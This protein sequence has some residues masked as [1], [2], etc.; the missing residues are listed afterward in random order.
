MRAPQ[1]QTD[2]WLSHLL[3]SAGAVEAQGLP[4]A[5]N[6]MPATGQSLRGQ[7][8]LDLDCAAA[9]Q[10]PL[11][12]PECLASSS[13]QRA[14]EIPIGRDK[15]TSSRITSLQVAAGMSQVARPLATTPVLSSL[16]TGR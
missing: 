10:V 1:G 5:S 15:R 11:A 2:R 3:A 16:N 14:I 8:L 7:F 6:D 12:L 9:T 13:V 4:R